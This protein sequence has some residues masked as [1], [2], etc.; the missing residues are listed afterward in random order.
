[1]AALPAVALAALH[2]LSGP[3]G[4]GAGNAGVEIHF[5]VRN[6]EAKT[7]KLFGFFNVP[8]TCSPS[9]TGA[10]S[11]N[12]HNIAVSGGK[13]SATKTLNA[14]HTTYKV[15]GKFKSLNKAVGT[16]SVTGAPAGCGSGSTGLQH[17]QAT[18]T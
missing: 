9:G 8:A 1:M 17:W 4:T 15:K 16:L 3:V 7:I 10:V 14:G 2:F 13:F 18:H 12:L 5:F 6:G 11:G